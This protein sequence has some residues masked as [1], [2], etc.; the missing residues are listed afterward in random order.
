MHACCAWAP[1]RLRGRRVASSTRRR[2]S[3]T[4]AFGKD[5]DDFEKLDA[6]ARHGVSKR[7][8]RLRHLAE[9]VSPLYKRRATKRFVSSLG[10]D[11]E[12]LGA[13][14]DMTAALTLAHGRADAAAT[15]RRAAIRLL[16]DES[17]SA[18]RQCE[19]PLREAARATPF[20]R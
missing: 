9:L 6:P 16:G 3:S 14:T 19:E 8:K 7:L 13:H 18:A 2:K 1:G 17:N 15:S 11:R 4:A 20:W 12:V 10:P 5:A